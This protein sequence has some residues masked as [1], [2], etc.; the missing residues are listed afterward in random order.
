MARIMITTREA[1]EM[2]GIG[3]RTYRALARAHGLR[4]VALGERTVRWR[5]DDLRQLAA[6]L[7]AAADRP[8]PPQLA[9]GKARI[10]AAR[11]AEGQPEAQ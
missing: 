5:T 4:P 7:A 6:S 11:V 8:E 10:R 2:L 3:E 9:A 1:A